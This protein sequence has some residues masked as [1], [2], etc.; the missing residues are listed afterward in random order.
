MAQRFVHVVNFWLKKGLTPEQVL[1]FERGATSLGTISTVVFAHLGQPAPTDRPVIDRS[2]DY[3][4]V[5]VFNHQQDHDAYQVDPIHDLFR[6]TCSSLWDRV[7]I[8]D[9]ISI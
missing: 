8:Y 1:Q 5:C 3:C 9:S 6:E 4:L 2:Y 7:L